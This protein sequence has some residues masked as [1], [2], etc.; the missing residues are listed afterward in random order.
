MELIKGNRSRV[1]GEHLLNPSDESRRH[2]TGYCSD[3][4]WISLVFCEICGK[5]FNGS[6]ILA[7]CDKPW[8]KI[9]SSNT[10]SIS[11]LSFHQFATRSLKFN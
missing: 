11:H 6:S 1:R 8:T 10:L 9:S 4:V 3:V 2:I 7:R 5:S